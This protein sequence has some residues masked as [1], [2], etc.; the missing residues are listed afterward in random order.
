[1]DSYFIP[2]LSYLNQTVARSQVSHSMFT[3]RRTSKIKSAD[4]SAFSRNVSSVSASRPAFYKLIA[5]TLVIGSTV[6][7]GCGQ[8]GDLYL[9]E[10]ST[11]TVETNSPV[12]DS[13]S[14]PQDAAFAK[15]DDN[16]NNQQNAD[17]FQLPKPSTD[18]ND[19]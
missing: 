10:S 13:S 3:I 4:A 9:V 14:H 2:I 11:Q 15:I 5:A 18:P 8:K 6:L 16:Q 12:L 17:D 7:T 19:Y 1:M